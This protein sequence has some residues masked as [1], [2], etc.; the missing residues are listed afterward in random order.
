MNFLRVNLPRSYTYGAQ[1]RYDRQ[2]SYEAASDVASARYGDVT[3][4]WEQ[5][6]ADDA[7]EM[8]TLLKKARIQHIHLKKGSKD[9]ELLHEDELESLVGRL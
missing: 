3:G 9:V 4:N 2:D 8:C 6:T 7:D 5:L 1:M